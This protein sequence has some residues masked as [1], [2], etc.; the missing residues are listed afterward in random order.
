MRTKNRISRLTRSALTGAT[1]SIILGLVISPPARAQLTV[2]FIGAIGSSLTDEDLVNLLLGPDSGLVV[3]NVQ[4]TGNPACAGAFSGGDAVGFSDGV[5][6]GSGRVEDAVGPNASANTT[7][8]FGTPG[9]A[10]LNTLVVGAVALSQDA[11]ILQF[12]FECEEGS[13]GDS[14]SFRY[15][16]ASEEYNE[17]TNTQFTDVFGF[18]LN[19]INIALLPDSTPVQINTVNGGNPGGAIVKADECTNGIDDDSDGLTDGDDPDC[20]TPLDNIVGELNSNSAAFINNACSEPDGGAACPLDVEADG[21]TVVL[22][23][24]GSI[25]NPG[26]NTIRLAIGDV[27]DRILDSWVFLEAGSF[28]CTTP[29]TLPVAGCVA[30]VNPS[31]QRIPPAGSTTLPGTKGGQNEDGFYQLVAEDADGDSVEIFVRN[32]DGSA[33]FGPFA[34]GDTVKITEAPDAT[35]TSKAIGGPNSAVV[36]HLILDSDPIVF[37]VDAAGDESS[38]IACLVPPLPK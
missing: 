5:V 34:A 37:A 30:S 3:S 28:Q 20:T 38:P 36:A 15:V 13:L 25:D 31:G 32:A 22:G 4:L 2:D 11:C 1:L 26:L 16:F 12:D 10:F 9:D 6:L 18:Q 7:T 8:D 29:N 23:A 35:P 27:G 19:G 21:L 33:I 17:Y 24:E 14:L